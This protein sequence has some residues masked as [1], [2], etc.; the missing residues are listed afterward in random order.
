MLT[1][2][3]FQARYKLLIADADG[4][5]RQCTVPNQPCPNQPDQWIVIPAAKHWFSQVDWSK[6]YF[7]IASNQGGIELGYLSEKLAYQM[8]KDL[9]IE[10]TGH[11]PPLGSLQICSSMDKAHP[12]RKPNPGMLLKIMQR[13]LCTPEQT[14]YVGDLASDRQAAEAAG[15]DFIW[16]AD[17]FALP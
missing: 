16:A 5:L 15:C 14:L 12:D 17:L 6:S 10:L 4:T 3:D 7:A 9:A 2:Q 13:W 8:L 11:F 1:P